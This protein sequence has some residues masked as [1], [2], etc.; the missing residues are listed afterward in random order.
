MLRFSSATFDNYHLLFSQ[1]SSVVTFTFRDSLFRWFPDTKVRIL[2]FS[3]SLSRPRKQERVKFAYFTTKKKSFA[4][5]VRSFFF[6]F[7]NI[8][9]PFSSCPLHETTCWRVSACR[10]ILHSSPHTNS[11]PGCSLIYLFFLIFDDFVWPFSVQNWCF[12]YRCDIQRPCEITI[13]KQITET[14]DSS[15]RDMLGIFDGKS[16]KN[17]L[18]H[19]GKGHVGNVGQL[20]SNNWGNTYCGTRV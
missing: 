16:V 18:A 8:S 15:C 12:K 20:N 9:Q 6:L 3:S 11:V 13:D 19:K 14:S 7:S 17:T 10:Q 1:I 4:R 5:F 2:L